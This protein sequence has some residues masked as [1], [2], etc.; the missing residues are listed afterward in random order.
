M[1]RK[2]SRRQFLTVMGGTM[3]AVA[4]SACGGT[5]TATP[6]PPTKAPAPAATTAP[7]AP[8]AAATAVPPTKAPAPAATAAPAAPVATPVVAATVPPATVIQ[9]PLWG[10]ATVADYEKATGKKVPA[11]KESPYAADLVK[12]GKLPAID[13]RLPEEPLVDNP[14][15]KVG[16]FGGS[17]IMGQVSTAVAYPASNF[18][19]FE[20]LFNLA[21]DGNTVVP[22]IAKKWEFGDGGK[23]FTIFL[24]KGLKWSNGDDFTADDIMFYW[25]DIANNKEM[26]PA[27][28]T[29]YA[30][31]GKPMN[32]VK[33]DD[34]TVRLDFSTPYYAILPNL[35]SVSFS[36]C[37]GD[38]YESAKYL[39]QFHKK[40]NPKVE[41]DAKAA[42]FDTWVQYFASKRYNWTAAKLG[43]PTMG[44]WRIT[45][46]VPEGTVM[47]RNPYYYKVDTEGNQLP[48]I[49]TVK[50][51][52]FSDTKTLALKM[53]AGEYDYQDWSTAVADYPAFAAA[54]D[55]GNFRVFMAPSLWTSIAAYSINQQWTGDPGRRGHPA[56]CPLPQ[57]ALALPSTA[58]RST[59]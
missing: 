44:P 38:I 55:K 2:I 13:K 58:T 30:P 18:T 4:V 21:R 7:A 17:L 34:Y 24:R 45:Q 22:N 19:T 11:Y 36:G 40:Y 26:S 54:Q 31:G 33:V 14:F 29:K 5:P 28:P 51:T 57:G 39:K 43:V 48:Y 47:E 49:D 50:A 8:A 53:V 16:K 46:T 52:I 3:A 37:Q 35:S 6:V 56:R 59:R 27:V 23:T 10:W 12:A 42:G 15:E 1:A 41:D 20:S 9:K 32:L 25:E